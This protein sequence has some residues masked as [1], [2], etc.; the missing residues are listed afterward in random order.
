MPLLQSLDRPILITDWAPSEEFPIFPIGSKPKRMV[1]CPDNVDEDFL[2]R[3]HAYLFKTARGWQEQQA[4]TEVI[5]YR[6]A[7]LVGIQ[8][9]PAFIAVDENTRET[10]ALIE[11]FYGYPGQ[12]SPPRLVH[13]SDIMTRFLRDKKHGRPHILRRNHKITQTFLG[14]DASQRWWSRT[15]CFDALIRNTDR[16]PE[17][18]GLLVHL[19]RNAPRRVEMAPPFDNAT[20]LGYEIAEANLPRMQGDNLDRYVERGTHHC[21]LAGDGP[22]AHFE[23]C[24]ALI[25]EYQ[26]TVSEIKLL[27]RM[28]MDAVGAF[29]GE[30]TGC[31]ASVAFSRQRAD[32]TLRLLSTR[33]TRLRSLLGSS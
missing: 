16:H 28:D 30:A 19:A 3:G 33:L 23:L 29:L 32:F 4:W 7:N 22:S 18:W 17:N 8:V 5:A 12:N 15:L 27:S 14:E 25:N 13:G 6:V 11:F 31:I 24:K 2:V 21:G 26:S 10:G 1:I 9:P 20:S